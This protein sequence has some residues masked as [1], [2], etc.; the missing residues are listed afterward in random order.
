M[1][2]QTKELQT[3]IEAL[4][5]AKEIIEEGGKLGYGYDLNS[6]IEICDK[7]KAFGYNWGDKWRV[8]YDFRVRKNYYITNSAT[9]YKQDKEKYYVEWDNGNVGRLQFVSWDY[10]EAVIDEWNE[11]LDTL[12]S[13]NP[14]DY[15]PLNCHIIYDVENGKKVMADYDRICEKTRK[16]INK[17]IEKI[18]IEELKKQLEE[19]ESKN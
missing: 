9:H 12:K 5:K 2:L 19:L 8:P 1:E 7:L 6:I 10:Y 11:F 16:K 15:D 4:T 13:Y 18:R 17:K 3:N 14:V